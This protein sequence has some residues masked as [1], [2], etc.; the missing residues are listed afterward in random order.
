V[1]TPRRP[2]WRW[3][4]IVQLANGVA[5][6]VALT[7][8]KESGELMQRAY[9]FKCNL[10]RNLLCTDLDIQAAHDIYFGGGAHRIIMESYLLVGAEP[11]YV[12]DLLEMT[13]EQVQVYNDLFFDVRSRLQNKPAIAAMLFN[14]YPHSNV[15]LADR[16]GLAHR[17]AYL[18]G[19]DVVDGI[20]RGDRLDLLPELYARLGRS[21]AVKQAM[22]MAFTLSSHGE[23]LPDALRVLSESAAPT[24]EDK[25]GG[26][27]LDE[28][29][30]VFMS[31]ISMSVAD[32]TNEDN[33]NMPA[34]E[35]REH[36]Y[37]VTNN[38]QPAIHVGQPLP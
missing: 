9:R 29:A 18:G 20:I 31:A 24:K 15:H 28:L 16:L 3:A 17:I 5:Q 34:R 1:P 23:A 25:K 12:G 19:F 33:L 27:E 6:Y 2:D 30:E 4:E 36:E 22:E 38:E 8:L 32:P 21:V 10:D 13:A 35:L 11:A 14:G 26:S 7:R 37:K